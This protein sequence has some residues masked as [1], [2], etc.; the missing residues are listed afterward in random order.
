MDALTRLLYPQGES[1]AKWDVDKLPDVRTSKHDKVDLLH[2]AN[3]VP[4]MIS[5]FRSALRNKSSRT[6]QQ[7]TWDVSRF[8]IWCNEMGYGIKQRVM[9]PE[10]NT[11]EARDI[12][13]IYNEKLTKQGMSRNTVALAM[14]A[15]KKFF[16]NLNKLKLKMDIRAIFNPDTITTSDP[17]AFKRQPRI[18][19]EIY[20]AVLKYVNEKGT[21]NEKWIFYLLAWGCRRSEIVNAK[22]GDID[23]RAKVIRPYMVKTKDSKTIPLPEWYK[24]KREF[25]A[26]Q[27]FII[28]YDGHENHLPGTKAFEKLAE[29]TKRLVE[30]NGI[31]PVKE[32][33][34]YDVI[35]RWLE[36]CELKNKPEKI[37]PHAFRRYF[38]NLMLRKGYSDTA[39]A[40]VGG[41]RNT[42]LISKYGHEANMKNNPIIRDQAVKTEMQTT[43]NEE[44]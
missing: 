42:L 30:R 21:K 41:W 16:D 33:Y 7:Y 26:N 15:L 31:Y 32:Q 25:E 34:I 20:N 37:S 2:G 6:Q 3:D 19:D 1:P 43:N 13:M 9:E 39:I 24:S 35:N 17:N 5:E 29:S 22:V 36:N 38:V 10:P 12:V 4:E 8:L 23:I 27:V 28:K 40:A 11:I 14:Q 18:D 44:Q